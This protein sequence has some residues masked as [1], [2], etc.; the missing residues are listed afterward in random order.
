MLARM[1]GSNG[2]TSTL[3]PTDLSVQIR[4]TLAVVVSP[5]EKEFL[6]LKINL[7][8]FIKKYFQGK[9]IFEFFLNSA[10]DLIISLFKYWI[11][12]LFF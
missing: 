5:L 1:W 11:W 3:I 10:K 2:F 9:L 6:P 8:I 4:P 7:L 12:L